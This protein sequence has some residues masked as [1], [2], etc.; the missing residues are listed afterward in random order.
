V[1]RD[2]RETPLY[3]EVE[4]HFRRLCEPGFG[5][6][7]GALDPHPSPDGRSVAFT[8]TKL[9]KLEGTPVSRITVA[10]VETGEIEEVTAG[11][12]DDRLP[13]WSPDGARLAFLSDRREKGQFQLYLLEAGR[14]GEATPTPPVDGTVEYLAW[15]PDGTRILLGVAGRGA[16]RAG[17]EGSGTTKEAQQDLP[18]WIPTVETASEQNDWRRLYLH[19]I[20]S[21]TTRLLS[22]DGLNAWEATWCGPDA[23]AAMVSD[24]PGEGAWYD[25]PLALIDAETGN[26]RVL[27]ATGRSDRQLAWPAGSPSGR[28]LAMVRGLASDRQIVAGDI[29]LV[30]PQTGDAT[31]VDTQGCDA[32][33]LAWRD[34]DRL[35]Y[36]GIRD[37]DTVA[38]EID[39]RSGETTELWSNGESFGQRYPQAEPLGDD[40]FVAVLES[41]ER[42]PEIA[43]FRNGKPETAAS[44]GNDGSRYLMEVG[45][46]LE[47]VTW[48]APDGLEINGLLTVP[49]GPGPHPVVLFPH[50]GPISAYRNRWSMGYVM[51]PLLVSRGYAVFHP[52][53]RGSS[54]RGQGFADHVVGDMGGGDAQDLL[55][56]LDA[57]IERGIADPERLGVTGG[58]YGG[59]MTSW[60]VTR[61]DRFAAAVSMSPVN[62]YYSQHWTS[63]IGYWDSIFLGEKPGPG[64]EYFERSP[65]M[66]AAKVRTPV[67]SV[68]GGQ[69]RCTPAGQAVEFHQAL[70]ENGAES[71]LVIYPEEGHGVRQLPAQ[72]DLCTRMVDWFERHM[73]ARKEGHP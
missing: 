55:T 73:P 17:A 54:G 28:R 21:G 56:G 23:I 59:F 7:S 69:D 49:G 9:E 37:L 46:R 3:R 42:P 29:L 62:D 39:A 16:D 70:L 53:P 24:R 22:R 2:L 40:A 11:P 52:N 8:G 68:A 26:E 45:G 20:Q 36:C 71:E 30:D 1:E 60:L 58:S 18:S 14:V 15:S 66:H 67:L 72:I 10:D 27:H 44:L 13:K 65:V 38:G 61:T 64:G 12:N 63:N 34:E 50:G 32:S 4:E 25:A 47:R 31:D 33:W 5:R 48:E 35:F 43:V 51:T 41:Y 57:L 19:D 6:I